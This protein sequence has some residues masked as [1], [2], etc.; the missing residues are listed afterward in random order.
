M[1]ARRVRCMF[2][3][4]GTP[5]AKIPAGE[6]P[7][8]DTL[9]RGTNALEARASSATPLTCRRVG[10]ERE[11]LLAAELFRH[12]GLLLLGGAGLLPLAG[13]LDHLRCCRRWLCL[14]GGR[15]VASRRGRRSRCRGGLSP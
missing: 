14:S 7:F 12:A 10:I 1:L 13:F 9:R 8:E 15:Q 4:R 5:L 3:L 2:L 11:G 6:R